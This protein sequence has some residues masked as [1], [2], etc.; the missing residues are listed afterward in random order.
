MSE[1]NVDTMTDTLQPLKHGDRCEAKGIEGIGDGRC[2]A[3]ARVRAHFEV[4]SIDFCARHFAE[5][6]EALEESASHIQDE[7]ARIQAEEDK[8]EGVG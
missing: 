4:G 5:N 2:G 1:P 7:S 3:R 6:E 8:R